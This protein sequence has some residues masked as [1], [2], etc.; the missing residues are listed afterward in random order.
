MSMQ[1]KVDKLLDKPVEALESGRNLALRADR[2]LPVRVWIGFGALIAAVVL[3]GASA[4]LLRD[5]SQRNLEYMP[6]MAYSPAWK[7]QTT[8]PRAR[9][10]EVLPERIAVW[11]TA[12]LPP[13]EGTIYRGQRRLGIAPGAEGL[14]QSRSLVNPY[15][16]LTGNERE[17]VLRRGQQLFV[18]NCQACHNVNGAGDAPVTRFGIGAPQINDAIT[19]D[20]YTDG[21]LVHIITWGINTM[22][23][24]SSH[25]DL[26]DRWKVVLYLRSLQEGR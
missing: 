3:G 5:F 23:A 6:D 26:D 17:A 4:Y 22:P 2:E 7:S 16:D 24:H 19:R 1:E 18:M 9:G 8:H 11:G 12:D 10:G 20:K 14:E 13:P 25:V 15:A 21:E